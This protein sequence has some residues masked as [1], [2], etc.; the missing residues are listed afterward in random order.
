MK[1]PCAF[2]A[3]LACPEHLAF[4]GGAREQERNFVS[5][6]KKKYNKITKKERFQQLYYA[7]ARV[8]IPRM[9]DGQAMS[10]G[11]ARWYGSIGKRSGNPIH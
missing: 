4:M 3:H 6:K 9:S 7:P 5:L 8:A 2:V 1:C 11:P 10:G